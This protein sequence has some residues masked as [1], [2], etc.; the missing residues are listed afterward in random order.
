MKVF[1][2]DDI[3]LAGGEI[4]RFV[5][6]Y[7][8]K[9]RVIIS[10]SIS[11][12]DLFEC[13][14]TIKGLQS[15][16]IELLEQFDNITG[17]V[18]VSDNSGSLW[19]DFLPTDEFKKILGRRILVET[20][21]DYRLEDFEMGG[22][23]RELYIKDKEGYIKNHSP[24]EGHDDFEGKRKCL[25]CNAVFLVKDYKVV[26]GPEIDFIC[27]PN[28]PKCDGD[29]LDWVKTEEDIRD[30]D[31]M[32]MIKTDRD[33]EDKILKTQD[34]YLERYYSYREIDNFVV[35]AKEGLTVF[36][37]PNKKKMM[38]LV[39]VKS[40][41]ARKYGKTIEK[42]IK[43]EQSLGLFPDD[44]FT[45]SITFIKADNIKYLGE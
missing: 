36:F 32:E 16:L 25:Q 27:C 19:F 24:I 22:G 8:G 39:I 42:I 44:G 14:V 23:P 12:T 31:P 29:I 7:F 21:K 34:E 43:E 9:S 11:E 45:P 6:K 33:T 2:Y 13:D 4:L 37:V 3:A 10:S 1:E 5:K 17:E 20:E 41:M 38:Q 30:G 26:A 35:K 15:R 18:T 28:Y 40:S